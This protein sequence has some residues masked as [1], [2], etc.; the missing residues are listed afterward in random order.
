MSEFIKNALLLETNF[1]SQLALLFIVMLFIVL[2]IICLT[3][4]KK[5]KK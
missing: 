1:Q 4:I 5:S 2:T 3:I